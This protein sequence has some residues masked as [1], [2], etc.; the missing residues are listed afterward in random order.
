MAVP[1]QPSATRADR[2]VNFTSRY[3]EAEVILYGEAKKLTFKTYKRETRT[4]NPEDKVA[5]IPPGMEYR[6]DLVSQQAYGVPDFW[7]RILEVNRIMDIFDFKA[8]RTIVIPDA[9]FQ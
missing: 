2:I 5:V 9:I 7:W 3:S 8:G 1:I 4:P 6:P